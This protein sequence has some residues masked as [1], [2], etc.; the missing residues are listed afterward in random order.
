MVI[1][2]AS[3]Y[4]TMKFNTGHF[5]T[6]EHASCINVVNEVVLDGAKRATHTTND[7]ALF[8]V[9]NMVIAN[10]VAAN[11][12]FIPTILQS[13]P[14]GCYVT[15]CPLFAG[16]IPLVSILTQRYTRTHGVLN[17]IVFNDP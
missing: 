2:D 8:A 6:A 16:I 4:C 11:S 5:C 13:P 15:L 14:N 10:N 9:C 17:G 3:I 12:T 7:A 1:A